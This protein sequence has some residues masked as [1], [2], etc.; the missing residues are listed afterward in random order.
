MD[1]TLIRRVM[2]SSA[3]TEQAVIGSI[4]MDKDEMMNV[5]DSYGSQESMLL[6][7]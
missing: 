5:A 7:E 3:E 1:D 6:Q 2:P 4:L